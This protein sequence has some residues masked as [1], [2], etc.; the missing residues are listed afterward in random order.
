MGGRV[1]QI[2]NNEA[3]QHLENGKISTQKRLNKQPGNRGKMRPVG[4][5]WMS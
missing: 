5:S 1:A 3:H 2:M 4:A